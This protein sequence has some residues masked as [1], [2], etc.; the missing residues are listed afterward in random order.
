MWLLSEINM[1][2]FIF[3]M[4]SYWF[5]IAKI[6]NIISKLCSTGNAQDK[7]LI[8]NTWVKEGNLLTWLQVLTFLNGKM[9]T[10]L[11]FNKQDEY[12][13]QY[14]YE[15]FSNH[16]YAYY[17]HCF[18]EHNCKIWRSNV[19]FPTL[20]VLLSTLSIIYKPLQC[21]VTSR[22]ELLASY[23]SVNNTC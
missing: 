2:L 16:F 23:V 15:M 4:Y 9:W 14:G 12:S 8:F 7:V 1:V 3:K 21:I 6:L 5:V 22:F 19:Q 18:R 13:F 11:N 20:H 10:I 17:P